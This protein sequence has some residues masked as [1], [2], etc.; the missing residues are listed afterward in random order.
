VK[1]LSVIRHAKSDWSNNLSDMD[2]PISKRGI[3]D[4]AVMSKVIQDLNLKPQIIF[5]SPA[6]RTIE[7]Y[8][9]LKK[10]ISTFSEISFIKSEMLYDFSGYNVIK[11][12]NSIDEKY[13]NVMIFSHNNSC[14]FLTAELGLN[15]IHVPTCGLLIFDFDVSLWSKVSVGKFNHYFPK[16]F[17]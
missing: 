17:R 16:S 9:Y 3:N 4:V 1:K 10:N 12:I 11:F 6:K 14:S 13:S 2:R 15:Y 5:S 8:E 7:T